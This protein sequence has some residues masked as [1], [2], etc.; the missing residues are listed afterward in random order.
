MAAC[1]ALPHK[2]SG[3]LYL[4]VQRAVGN[5]QKHTWFQQQPKVIEAVIQAQS[6]RFA[7]TYRRASDYA[8]HMI[9][10]LAFLRVESGRL[11][12]DGVRQKPRAVALPLQT[13]AWSF[14]DGPE[15]AITHETPL[16]RFHTQ[17]PRR[18]RVRFKSLDAVPFE[19]AADISIPTE[20]DNP[21]STT[22]CVDVDPRL[23][24]RRMHL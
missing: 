1:T 2:L 6:A 24:N 14:P 5:L 8:G 20:G 12:H 9:D 4:R 13:Q 22:E 18:D 23:G 11:N 21:I 19:S 16:A 7:P 10:R 3:K 17:T 15:Q